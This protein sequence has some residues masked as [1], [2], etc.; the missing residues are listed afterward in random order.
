MDRCST[1]SSKVW[2]SPWSTPASASAVAASATVC[3][4]NHGRTYCIDGFTSLEPTALGLQI[5]IKHRPDHLELLAQPRRLPQ[6]APVLVR[7]DGDHD[8]ATIRGLER[9][10]VR[11]IETVAQRPTSLPCR[12]HLGDVAEVADGREHD[13][14]QRQ[15]DLLALAPTSAVPTRRR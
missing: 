9:L 4:A 3:A 1:S 6:P 11:T 5:N 13:V 8:L 10:T 15:G 12:L 7:D 2:N 14:G